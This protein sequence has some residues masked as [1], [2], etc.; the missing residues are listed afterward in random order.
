MDDLLQS[1]MVKAKDLVEET[2]EI[3]VVGEFKF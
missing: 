1:D 2:I 3:C